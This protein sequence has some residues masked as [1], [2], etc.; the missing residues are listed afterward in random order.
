MV[1]SGPI[2]GANFTSDTKNYPWHQPP[3]F[4]DI[5]EALDKIVSRITDKNI[6]RKLVALAEVGIPLYRIAGFVIMEGISQGKWTTDLGLLLVGPTCKIIE[7]LCTQYDVE[8]DLGLEED[9]SFVTG[10]FVQAKMQG[11]SN[12]EVEKALPDIKAQ[13]EEQEA[14][15]PEGGEEPLEQQGFTAAP[16]EG[17]I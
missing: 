16:K 5:S 7:I 1:N 8:Y 14:A 10:L 9:E 15:P 17:V 3:E 11:M 6:S 13:A 4:T 2:P 12:D